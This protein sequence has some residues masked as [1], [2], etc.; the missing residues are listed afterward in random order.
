MIRAIQALR[1]LINNNGGGIRCGILFCT[2]EEDERKTSPSGR[3]QRRGRGLLRMTVGSAAP[4]RKVPQ[5]EEKKWVS[6][7]RGSGSVW[8]GRGGQEVVDHDKGHTG[9]Q[10]ASLA[11]ATKIPGISAP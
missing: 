9:S 6:E 2:T 4:F 8:S 11:R 10:R 1:L 5:G 7:G 3:F